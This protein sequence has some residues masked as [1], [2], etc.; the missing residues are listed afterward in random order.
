MLQF[1]L[2]K[3]IILILIII[4][5]SIVIFS[6]DDIDPNG[7]NKFY[8]ENGQISSEGNMRDGKPDGYWKTYY[9]NGL[10]KSEG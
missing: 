3:H 6:Q 5:S 10:L 9:E 7:F 1:K 4:F 2:M 8:Y